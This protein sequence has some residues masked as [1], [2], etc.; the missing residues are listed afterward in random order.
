MSQ[1]NTDLSFFCFSF[2][3]QGST[4]TESSAASSVG[5]LRAQELLPRAADTFTTLRNAKNQ[6]SQLLHHL[7]TIPPDSSVQLQD[8]LP[9]DLETRIR[10][11]AAREG[12]TLPRTNAQS[13][14]SITI[15]S[16]RRSTSPSSSMSPVSTL[17][18]A[19]EPLHLNELSAETVRHPADR[20]LTSTLNE[21]DKTAS[22]FEPSSSL[23]TRKQNLTSLSA[24]ENQRRQ[25][26]VGG[27]HEEP[28]P[29]SQGLDREDE[30]SRDDNSQYFKQDDELSIQDSSLSGVGAKHATV[31]TST[32]S[33]TRTGHISHVHLTLSPKSTDHSVDTTVRFSHTNAAPRQ[34]MFVP[35]RHSSPANSSP[36]EGVGSCSPL[37][38]NQSRELT[39]RRQPERADTSTLYK[40]AASHGRTMTST[41]TQ[42]ST[43][44]HTE[45]VSSRSLTPGRF[46]M[47]HT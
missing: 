29:P 24:P 20:K 25:D 11:I 9:T 36:D 47:I 16:C 38:W 1:F 17:S 35:L 8:S 19:P 34:N 31:S 33:Q 7:G 10:E 27:Q 37:E 21:E 30:T 26:A 40:P 12:V 32:E 23:Y 41:S 3:S 43:A 15:A 6:A 4:D 39:G 14:T 46:I 2:Q 28:L 45:E 18:P 22:V 5:G 42:S 44:P 13:L